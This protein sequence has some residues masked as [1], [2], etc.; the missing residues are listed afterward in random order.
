MIISQYLNNVLFK[1]EMGMILL[2]VNTFTY[3]LSF[4]HFFKNILKI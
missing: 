1:K 3:V 4:Y 2:I